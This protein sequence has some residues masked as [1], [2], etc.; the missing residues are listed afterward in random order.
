MLP[1]NVIYYG[2]DEPLP[3]QIALRAGP[4]SLVYE[5]G[6]LRYIRLGEHEI[7]RRIYVAVRDRNWDTV[8]PVLSN[9][10]IEAGDDTFRISYDADHSQG[11]IRFTWRATIAGD[12]DGTIRF[13][14]DGQA[15]TT[16]LRNRIGF[17]LLHPGSCAGAAA[18]I[19]HVDGTVETSQ[20]PLYIAPQALIDGVTHPVYPFADMRAV[21]REVAPGVW[22]TLRM[23]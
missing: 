12:A 5:N 15:L 1:T 21:S 6:D 20:F 10:Q 16:F 11:Q 22:A 17:C 7:V 18:R 2:K 8:L 14:M 23:D 19:E 3:E 9:L 13:A 4:L